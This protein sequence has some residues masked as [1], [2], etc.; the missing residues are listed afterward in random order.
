MAA[1]GEQLFH[2]LAK[3]GAEVDGGA[4]AAAKALSIT[5]LRIEMCAFIE[6]AAHFYVPDACQPCVEEDKKQNMLNIIRDYCGTNSLMEQRKTDTR[7]EEMEES[8]H[9]A[10]E[11][12]AV[13]EEALWPGWNQVK[14]QVH[15]INHGDWS[16]PRRG[17]K[18]E[19]WEIRQYF[20]KNEAI[21]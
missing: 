20:T 17:I 9:V 3:D 5:Q 1:N 10:R 13:A 2:E 12:K 15:K 8:D 7:K 4:L 16:K 14:K 6:Y 11:C 18:R 19:E 21:L